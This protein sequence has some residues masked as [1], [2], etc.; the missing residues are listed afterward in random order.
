M[1]KSFVFLVVL[2]FLFTGCQA[3]ENKETI[4]SSEELKIGEGKT[5]LQEEF[6]APLKERES[7][8]DL[9][10]KSQKEIIDLF[11][12]VPTLTSEEES[13]EIEN[14]H[15]LIYPEENIAFYFLEGKMIEIVLYPGNIL[16]G[17]KIEKVLD[18]EALVKTFG[19]PDERVLFRERHGLA[20]YM[21]KGDV[22]FVKE[23]EP[24]PMHVLM[25][26][27]PTE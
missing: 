22:L 7:F 3:K 6:V 23:S 18:E 21:N 5:I 24:T 25:F 14:A 1:K 11:E 4:E 20:Y 13:T 19:E 10:G 27:P 8:F 9:F 26:P 2:L 17:F 16:L 12:E 15:I